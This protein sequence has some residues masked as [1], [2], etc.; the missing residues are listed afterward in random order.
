MERNHQ[1]RNLAVSRVSRKERED[2]AL[3]LQSDLLGCMQPLKLA[4]E[5]ID[6]KRNVVPVENIDMESD[7]NEASSD[8]AGTEEEIEKKCEETL[9][10][11][12]L[13]D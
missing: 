12:L 5:E 10:Y 8:G 3:L 1:F 2:E 11:K 7:E 6:K 9:L 4:S 13:R